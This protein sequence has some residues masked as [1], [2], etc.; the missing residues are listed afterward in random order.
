MTYLR[1]FKSNSGNLVYIHIIE[2]K[3]IFNITEIK[4]NKDTFTYNIT[5][6]ANVLHV[7]QLTQLRQGMVT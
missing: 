3:D 4:V 6:L 7:L 2:W 5:N 1:K